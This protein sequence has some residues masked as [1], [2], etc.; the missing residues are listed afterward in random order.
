MRSAAV[1]HEGFMSRS[2][3]IL[4]RVGGGVGVGGH[5]SVSHWSDGGPSTL[6]RQPH[7]TMHDSL[8]R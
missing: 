5:A 6:T 1:I 7:A 2:R 4:P 3:M 8:A